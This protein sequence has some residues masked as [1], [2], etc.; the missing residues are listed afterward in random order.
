[1]ES[2]TDNINIV[3]DTVYVLCMCVCGW[4]GG[5]GSQNVSYVKCYLTRFIISSV[6]D[7]VYKYVK[8]RTNKIFI[9]FICHDELYQ[10]M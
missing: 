5:V 7:Y 1:M 8:K 2:H 9:I 6:L 3:I 4:G 10:N